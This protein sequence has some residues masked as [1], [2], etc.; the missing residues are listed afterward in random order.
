MYYLQLPEVRRNNMAARTAPSRSTKSI[1]SPRSTRKLTTANPKPRRTPTLGHVAPTA[2]EMTLHV[3][4]N[5]SPPPH[6]PAH[7]AVKR[8]FHH[9]HVTVNHIRPAA[10]QKMAKLGLLPNLPPTLRSRPLRITC[11]S[12]AAARQQPAS[13]HPTTHRYRVAAAFSSDICGPFNPPSR[14]GNKYILTVIDMRS[15]YLI[16]DF[17]ESRA[18]TPHRL[19][20]IL[21]ALKRRNGCK[22]QLIHTDNAKEYISDYANTMYRSHS[23]MHSTTVPHTPQ[24]NGI[25]ERING[26]LMNSARAALHHSGLPKTHWED[27]VRDAAFKYNNNLHHAINALPNTTW[28]N[29]APKVPQVLLFGQLGTIPELANRKHISKIAPRATPARYLHAID[30][31]HIMVLETETYKP[32]RVRCV[33]FWT[34]HSTTDPAATC[35]HAWKVFTPHRTPTRVTRTTPAQAGT[36]QA[37][38]IPT[39]LNGKRSTTGS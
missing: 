29:A 22:P 36:S 12:C 10:L 25:A 27:A 37:K 39:Q 16:V 34:Y 15:R 28:S 24:Q 2:Q 18:E 5:P 30:E 11:S 14:Q 8:Y 20:K 17:L 21:T 19:D 9:Y 31:Q 7:P 1:K 23:V 3:A 13:P 35:M 6:T 33:N 32:R 38:N 26:T 4:H